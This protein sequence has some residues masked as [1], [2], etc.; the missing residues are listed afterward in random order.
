MILMHF[1]DTLKSVCNHHFEC[2]ITGIDFC[3]FVIYRE[4]SI[5]TK[6]WKNFQLLPLQLHRLL[7]FFL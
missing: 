7:D 2:Q 6:T 3:S 1:E 4:N 5:F